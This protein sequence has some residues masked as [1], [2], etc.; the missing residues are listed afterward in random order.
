MTRED[1]YNQVFRSDLALLFRGFEPQEHAII[2][3]TLLL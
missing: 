2:R 1:Y 3:Q